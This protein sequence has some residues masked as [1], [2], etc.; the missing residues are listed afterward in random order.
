M[1]RELTVY[2]NADRSITFYGNEIFTSYDDTVYSWDMNDEDEI[3]WLMKYMREGY[4][5]SDNQI[6]TI[7]HKIL[8][9]KIMGFNE[10]K[11]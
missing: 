11:E 9:W 1:K 10:E 6:K 8:M 5:L 3:D 2:E 4:K 7:M